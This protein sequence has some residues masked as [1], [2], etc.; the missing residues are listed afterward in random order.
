M[1]KIK[2][3]LLISLLCLCSGKQQ[4][5]PTK[6]AMFKPEIIRV[7]PH[8][9]T[10]F[11]QGLIYTDGKLYEST[12]LV[13]QSTIRIVD[14]FG[15]VIT[16]KFLPEIFAEGCCFFN[17][18][19]YQITWTEQTCIVYK[20]DLTIIRTI[21]YQGEGWGLTADSKS[22]IMSNGS[23]T[24]YFRDEN[25]KIL[26]KLPVNFNGK[27]LKN[28]NELEFA[29]G[30]ILANVWFNDFIYEISPQTGSVLRTIDCTELVNLEK[31][32]SENNVLNGIAF[33]KEQNRFFLTGKNWKKMF[34]VK[35]PGYQ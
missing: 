11:T 23:D 16:R 10:A 25:F 7:I 1:S 17:G 28:L 21:A 18:L 33:I 34:L 22:L 27:P 4:D 2:F 6:V 31:P 14:T 20:P 29:N 9:S 19:L 30:K 3:F 24:L 8:D 5:M 35:I 13:G 26:R 15:T 12:G 32:D